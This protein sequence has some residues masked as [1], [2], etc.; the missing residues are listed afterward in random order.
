MHKV[1]LA[2]N[3]QPVPED[4]TFPKAGSLK[5]NGVRCLLFPTKRFGEDI[6]L[7]NG[8]VVKDAF[9][10]KALL[11]DGKGQPISRSAKE[12]PNANVRA[13]LADAQAWCDK[14]DRILD[15][16]IYAPSLVEDGGTLG[17]LMSI[18]ASGRGSGKSKDITDDMN[19]H[20]FDCMTAAQWANKDGKADS[21][22][23]MPKFEERYR[24]MKKYIKIYRVKVIEQVNLNSWQE[25]SDWADVVASKGGE[26]LILRKWDSLYQHRR[27]SLT[28]NDVMKIKFFDPMEGEVVEIV[29][30]NKIADHAV[31]EKD[32]FGRSK[33]VH[34]K[35]DKETTEQAGSIRVKILDGHVLFHFGVDELFISMGSGLNEQPENEFNRNWV[36]ENRDK[37]IGCILQFKAMLTDAK[38]VPTLPVLEHWRWDKHPRPDGLT[39]LPPKP[40]KEKK[41]KKF[42]PSITV[43]ND[44]DDIFG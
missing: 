38:D 15:G 23:H 19:Y 27:C 2:A 11:L 24:G 17:A 34:K 10:S 26:G 21:D 40:K 29:A 44:P 6:T 4:V 14:H 35:G 8:V 3:K 32:E 30:M 16:E 25:A 1:M 39:D 31:R 33:S 28:M 18:V 22:M 43:I 7:P 13:M 37:L 12:L 9:P 5:L 42:V 36:W 41:T 20:I